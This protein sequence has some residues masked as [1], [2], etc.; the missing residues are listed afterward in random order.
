MRRESAYFLLRPMA[1]WRKQTKYL[2]HQLQVLEPMRPGPLGELADQAHK[3]SDYL[4]DDHDLAVLR[5]KVLQHRSTFK[6]EADLTAFLALLDRCQERL[7]AK[8]FLVGSRIYAEK[9][10]TFAA[11]LGRYWQRWRAEKAAAAA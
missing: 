11:R 7:R 1:Q 3:L 4:G 10:A 9:P 5:E 8:A 2:W 6:D